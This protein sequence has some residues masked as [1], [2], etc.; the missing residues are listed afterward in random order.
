MSRSAGRSLS[1]IRKACWPART[2]SARGPAAA[3]PPELLAVPAVLFLGEPT[4]GL[5][6]SARRSLWAYARDIR[7][8]GTTVVLTTHYLDEAD[9]L[10]DRVAI[11]DRGCIRALG[12]PGE[13]KDGLAARPAG[14]DHWHPAGLRR[15]SSTRCAWPP[16][17][18]PCAA[19]CADPGIW[20]GGQAAAGG[21]NA[22]A[23]RAHQSA[24]VRG[25]RPSS[26][27]TVSVRSPAVSAR[28]SVSPSTM[29]SARAGGAPFG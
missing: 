13:L 10:C 20:A 19:T 24:K 12:T 6:I 7:A 9:R 22:V 21:G 14:Q 17:P 4:L 3:G 25:L 26:C 1:A 11:I 2:T 5:D 18:W 16:P 27:R 15:W 29:A 23:L 8:A 28:M